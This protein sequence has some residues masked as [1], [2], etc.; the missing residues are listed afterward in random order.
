M[1]AAGLRSA[2]TAGLA[3]FPARAPRIELDFV[4]VSEQIA[5]NDFHIP[6]VRFSD[7]RPLVCDFQVREA[8]TALGAVV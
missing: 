4:L 8:E 2:N 7:H 5:V 3:S 6:D 1:R